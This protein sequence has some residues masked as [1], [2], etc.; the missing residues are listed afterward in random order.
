MTHTDSDLLAV[1]GYIGIFVG[2]TI[3]CGFI[4][5]WVD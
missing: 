3:I 2:V 5:S 4:L 1:L